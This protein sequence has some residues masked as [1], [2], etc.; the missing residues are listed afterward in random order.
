MFSIE[1][2]I[3]IYSSHAK[4]VIFQK[5]V[6]VKYS[7]IHFACWPSSACLVDAKNLLNEL[8]FP[9]YTNIIPIKFVATLEY[10][11]TFENVC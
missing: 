8:T 10:V 11:P 5:G 9:I 3:H 1:R 4:D 2:D 7:G 6:I